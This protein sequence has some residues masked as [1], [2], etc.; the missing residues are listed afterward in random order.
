[1]RTSAIYASKS[2]STTERPKKTNIPSIFTHLQRHFIKHYKRGSLSWLKIL[3]ENI[4]TRIRVH[5]ASYFY[6]ACHQKIE[7]QLHLLLHL[8]QKDPTM[9]RSSP[10]LSALTW[11]PRESSDE[12]FHDRKSTRSKPGPVKPTEINGNPFIPSCGLEVNTRTSL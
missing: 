7:H 6:S 4:S 8:P 5:F 3:S 9:Q 2:T 10:N 12:A 1:M 11:Q